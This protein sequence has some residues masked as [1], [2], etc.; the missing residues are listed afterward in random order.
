[1]NAKHL[2]LAAVIALGSTAPAIAQNM[3]DNHASHGAA[4]TAMASTAMSEGSV[5]KIDK[6]AGKLT[7]AHGPL[8]N[9]GMPAMTMAFRVADAGMLD[10]VKA[11]DKIRFTAER[12]D[13][14]FTVTALEA[15][16]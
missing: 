16:N 5:R 4:A 7:I 9:L 8:A 6:T 13:G 15:A 2:I 10:K 1:M 14:A 3:H 11:G 12:V